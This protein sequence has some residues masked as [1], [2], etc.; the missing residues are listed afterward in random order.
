MDSSADPAGEGRWL[1]NGLAYFNSLEP[2]LARANRS[3]RI[4]V[5]IIG[6]DSVGRRIRAALIAAVGR[7]V[8]V[9]VL[10]DGLGSAEL[11]SGWW[12]P[13][14]KAG[15]QVHVFN[16]LTSRR[17]GIRDHRK[18][19]VVDDRMAWIGGIN[20]SD[21]YAGDGFSQG[22]ADCGFCVWGAAAEELSKEFDLMVAECASRQPKVVV[23]RIRRGTRPPARV[24]GKGLEL[25]VSGPGRMANAF[26]KSLREDVAGSRQVRF[27][28]A[29]FLPGYRMRQLLRRIARRGASVQIV[30]PGRSDV[31]VALRAARHLYSGLMRSG[32]EIWEYQPQVLHTKLFLA[33][34]AAYVGSSNLDTRSLHINYEIMLRL[35]DPELVS[36]G[37]SMFVD[38]LERSTRIDPVAWA[39]SR[40][41]LERWREQWAF[42]ILSRADPYVTRWL[43]MGPR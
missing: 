26:Q 19:V 23:G 8:Q 21:D 4:E 5:Y 35:T 39:T 37:Q 9:T 14:V 41:W 27:A 6:D 17:I 13:L 2:G 24:I 12:T 34:R 16:P 3:I 30:V 1:K 40:S 36:Q 42:W 15:G 18:L 31:P 20:L 32:V 11:P 25:M 43:A 38:L 10:A 28:V 7:G 29:Y 33:N 22:W